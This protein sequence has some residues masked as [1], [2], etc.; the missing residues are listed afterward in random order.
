[1]K[2]KEREK[3]RKRGRGGWIGYDRGRKKIK[4]TEEHKKESRKGDGNEGRE[5]GRKEGQVRFGQVKG[6][7]GL[8][9]CLCL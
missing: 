4:G 5:G 7:R 3:E 1:M 6:V 8:P 2:T 9:V